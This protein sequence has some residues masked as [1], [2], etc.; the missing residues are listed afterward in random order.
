MLSKHSSTN[1]AASL[2]KMILIKIFIFARQY[3]IMLMFESAIAG[4]KIG[5]NATCQLQGTAVNTRFWLFWQAA[6]SVAFDSQ[7]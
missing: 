4:V 6:V 2:E 7:R 5:L 3:K 1:T